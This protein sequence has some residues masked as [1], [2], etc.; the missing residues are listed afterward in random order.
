[1]GD[2]D[3]N[4]KT[5]RKII[6]RLE[7]KLPQTKPC[8]VNLVCDATYFGRKI[9]KDGLLIFLDSLS[10]KILWFKFISS[11]TKHEYQEGLN[12]LESAGIEIQSVTIDGR[13]GISSVFKKYPVQICQFHV[14]ASVLRRTT[15]NP[16]TRAGKI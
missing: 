14:Q 13:R 1:M 16:K 10:G 2:L 12:Y 9:D 15:Q 3:L 4:L 6:D 8:K 7:F 11:E 5:T